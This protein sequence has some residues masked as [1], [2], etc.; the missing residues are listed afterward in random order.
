MTATLANEY[1]ESCKLENPTSLVI[2]VAKEG[3][4]IPEF[5]IEVLGGIVTILGA[6]KLPGL[7]YSIKATTPNPEQPEYIE[8][9][10]QT[11]LSTNPNNY[12]GDMLLGSTHP[13]IHP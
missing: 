9:S 7:N 8:L 11:I 13:E 3:E 6:L 10:T 1:G 2:D 4:S 12:T 5:E